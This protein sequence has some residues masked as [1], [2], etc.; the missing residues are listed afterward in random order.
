MYNRQHDAWVLNMGGRHGTPG[1]VTRDNFVSLGGG[2]GKMNRLSDR[3][4]TEGGSGSGPQKGGE[5]KSYKAWRTAADQPS[6]DDRKLR[7]LKKKYDLEKTKKYE[8]TNRINEAGPPNLIGGIRTTAKRDMNYKRRG[9]T[10]PKGTKVQ[11]RF[12]KS[13]P[14]RAYYEYE[15]QW[16]AIFLPVASNNWTGFS[17]IPSKQRL[18]KMSDD[19]ISTTPTGKRV[20]PDG[21]GPDGSPSWMLAMELI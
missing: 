14:S 9:V 12:S 2:G 17:K 15:G 8:E 19:G 20:E 11:A 16:F 4:R 1:V 10:V 6:S 7:R 3:P 13:R 5:E 21:H 18:F